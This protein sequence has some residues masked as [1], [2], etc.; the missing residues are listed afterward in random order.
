MDTALISLVAASLALIG[1]HFAMSHPLRSAIVNMLGPGGFSGVYSL[2]SLA[3]TIWMYLA[4]TAAAPAAPLWGGFGDGM[5]IIA[6]AL[7]LLAMI[8]FAGSMRGNPALPSPDADAAAIAGPHGVFQVTRH[9]MFWGFALWGLAHIIAAPTP[10]TLIVAGTVVVL[11]LVGANLQDR[12]KRVLMGDAW[13]R[14]EASTQYWPR[15]SKLPGAGIGP[16]LAGTALWL[17]FTWLHGWLGGL[18]AGIWR[19]L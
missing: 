2:V 9:P 4:F 6:S 12:K 18:P 5:W 10:R 15:W 7:T 11:S 3:C 14:W 1:T 13:A 16:I 17:A 19:W 8:L